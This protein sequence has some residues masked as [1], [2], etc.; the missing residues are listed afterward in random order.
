MQREPR[1]SLALLPDMPH[2]KNM[3]PELAETW[4]ERNLQAPPTTEPR[5]VSLVESDCDD[6]SPVRQVWPG[7]VFAREAALGD[8]KHDYSKSWDISTKISRWPHKVDCCKRFSDQIDREKDGKE[9]NRTER[10]ERILLLFFF[11][12]LTQSPD[13]GHNCGLWRQNPLILTHR[14]LTFFN[15]FIDMSS[16]ASEAS[17]NAKPAGEYHL[18]SSESKIEQ[19]P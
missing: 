18:S 5:I 19:D 12:W 14:I 15:R 9:I 7:H 10:K 4:Q 2:N 17:S 13:H 16:S 11:F 3:H 8:D 6:L 1:A